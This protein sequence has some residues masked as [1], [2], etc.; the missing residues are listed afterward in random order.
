MIAEINTYTRAVEI[1]SKLIGVDTSQIT[2]V[3]KDYILRL[4]LYNSTY[5]ESI[6]Y[7][8]PTYN[9]E[10]LFSSFSNTYKL[11]LFYDSSLNLFRVNSEIIDIKEESTILIGGNPYINNTLLFNSNLFKNN[12]SFI[13]YNLI[14]QDIN[15]INTLLYNG[16]DCVIGYIDNTIGYIITTPNIL[17]SDKVEFILD[18]KEKELL[19]HDDYVS[20]ILNMNIHKRLE[21]YYTIDEISYFYKTMDI[22]KE[23]S[24]YINMIDLSNNIDN[25]FIVKYPVN[26]LYRLSMVRIHTDFENFPYDIKLL[27]SENA[28]SQ[29]KIGDK[30]LDI[31]KY[32]KK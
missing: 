5:K 26:V 27:E 31:L 28:I 14:D 2:L 24:S 17:L 1:F 8:Y 32:N 21:S 15:N 23:D 22:K 9:T 16:V 29:I 11:P 3:P 4:A 10:S 13:I 6:Y 12:K 20:H 7:E 19:L 30:V 25:V 18:K